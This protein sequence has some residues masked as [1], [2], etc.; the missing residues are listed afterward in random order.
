MLKVNCKTKDLKFIFT[1]IS[2][3]LLIP[4]SENGLRKD[5]KISV[6]TNLR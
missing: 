1:D 2:V 6:K 5:T 4:F 3:S